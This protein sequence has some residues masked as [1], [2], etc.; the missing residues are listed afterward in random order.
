MK[1]YQPILIAAG[2]AL[3]SAALVAA[4]TVNIDRPADVERSASR[5][6][7][8]EP[9]RRLVFPIETEPLCAVVNGFGAYSKTYGRGGH[10]GL[11]IGALEGQDI[12]AVAN[13]RLIEEHSGGNGGL[14]WSLLS[15]DDVEYR[16]YHME[17]LTKG[18]AVGDRVAAGDVIGTVGDTGNASNGGWHLHFEVRPGPDYEPVDPYPLVAPIPPEC[19]DYVGPYEDT[20][21]T[22][23]EPATTAPATS[24]PPTTLSIGDIL[25]D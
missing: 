18:L 7:P 6:E 15:N 14:G 1:R 24:G 23:T 19:E 22:T 8:P 21:A 11:D 4:D 5:I 12:F 17:T 25:R 9:E 3:G 10:E 13:G 16:F 2:V 20:P